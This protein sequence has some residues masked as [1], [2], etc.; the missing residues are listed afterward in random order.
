M[1]TSKVVSLKT[2]AGAIALLCVPLMTQAADQAVNGC[3]PG[4]VQT[5][6]EFPQRSQEQGEHG[7]VKLLVRLGADGRA[8]AVAVQ[9]SSGFAALDKAAVDSVSNHWRF[10]VG[11]C[12]PEQLQLAYDVAVRFERPVRYTLS[13]SIDWKAVALTKKLTNDSQCHVSSADVDTKVFTCRSAVQEGER[14]ADL[15]NKAVAK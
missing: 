9:Q 4:L 1:F 14:S 7:D 8:S 3:K 10:S 2:L 15:S 11:Q 13:N 12:S 6:T 5:R